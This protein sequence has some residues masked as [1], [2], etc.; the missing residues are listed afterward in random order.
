MRSAAMVLLAISAAGSTAAGQ[1]PAEKLIATIPDGIELTGPPE[2]DPDGKPVPNVAEVVF[3]KDGGQVAYVGFKG[4]RSCPV[5]GATVGE[6]FDYLDTPIFGGEHVFF[7]A[8][9]RTSPTTEKW[10][11]L[12]DGKRTGEEDWIGAIACN[13]DGSQLAY[14]VQP[15]AKIERDGAYSRSNLS[16]VVGKRRGQKWQDAEALTAPAFSPDGTRVATAAMKGSQWFALVAGAKGEETRGAGHGLISGIAWRPDGQ[17]IA[18]AAVA[19][20]PKG[21][22]RPPP[23]APP[24]GAFPSKFVIVYG[25]DVFGKKYDCAGSPAFSPDG[26]KLAFKVLKG[27]K[28]G[29]AIG[30]DESVEPRFDFVGRPVFSTTGEIAYAAST[31]AKCDPFAAVTEA[32]EPDAEGGEWFVMIGARKGDVFEK[33]GQPVFSPDGKRV[34]HP[35]RAAGKWHVV[36]D[37]AKSPPFDAVGPPVFSA[38]GKQV[39]FGARLGRELWWKV[40]A[41]E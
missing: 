37:K 5:V 7:R 32:G 10:W 35:A 17:E 18:I 29:V 24:G 41:V 36:V 1:Q 38:D 4:G 16:L 39:S 9:N 15:G 13:A 12:A 19:S 33:V 2:T 30:A 27:S 22:R 40:M 6:T 23:G 8:G 25:K 11:V 34:A 31:G 28:L 21:A 20:D 14:W 26:K 3:R